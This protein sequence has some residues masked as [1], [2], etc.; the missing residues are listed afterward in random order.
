MSNGCSFNCAGISVVA[1][2]IVGIIAAFL[3]ITGVITVSSAFL[4]VVFG[5]AIVYLAVLLF[6]ASVSN[7]SN[8]RRCMCSILNVL[9]VGI[10]GAILASIILLAIEFAVTSIIGAVLVGAL[11][12]FFSLIIT[13][14]ACLVRCLTRCYDND[15]N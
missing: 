9:L 4:W 15:E 10:L 14:T 8:F 5:I 13:A 12:F 1:S 6:T 3:R 11:I 7:Y 2:I